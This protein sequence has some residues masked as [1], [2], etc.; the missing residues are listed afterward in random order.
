MMGLAMLAQRIKLG[1]IGSNQS[2]WDWDESI[3]VGLAMVAKQINLGGRIWQGVYKF[4]NSMWRCS[5]EP[6][7]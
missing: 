5:A 1:G 7:G 3:W 2:V 6:H 4:Y